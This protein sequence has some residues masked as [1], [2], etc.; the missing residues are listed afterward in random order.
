MAGE[1]LA[2]S[3]PGGEAAQVACAAET[4]WART[5][6]SG[7]ELTAEV[8]LG[9]APRLV[10]S[11]CLRQAERNL[12]EH[13]AGELA[14]E[15]VGEDGRTLSARWPVAGEE[16]WWRRELDLGELAGETV[17]LR[18][19]THLAGPRRLFLADAVVEHQ[20][21]PAPRRGTPAQV[22]LVSIDTLR[23][24][25]VAA[26]GGP[27]PTPALDRLV[28]EG[29]V[30]TRHYAG[31][32]WTKPSHANLLTGRGPE[33][34]RTTGYQ[35]VLHPAAE[36]LAERF[37][38]GGFR[39]AGLVHDCVWLNPEFGF[40]R[41]FDE[42]RAVKWGA[43]PAV[44]ET[45]GWMAEHRGEPFFYF[46]HL[47][48]VHSDFAVLPYEGPGVRQ[49]T[50]EERFGVEG[51]GC[52][53]GACASSMLI[54]INDG[55]EPIPEEGEILRFL[56]GRGVS[57]T[58]AALGAL[59]D[60]LRR[61]GMWDDLTVAVTAD[62]GEAFFEHGQVLHEGWWDEVTR[63]PLVIKWPRGA[64]AGT[65]RQGPS[66]SI[67]V[68][69]TLLTA[70]GLS[71]GDLPGADLR[72]RRADRPV[73]SGTAWRTVVAGPLKAVFPHRGPPQLYDLAGDPGEHRD[74]A[75]E[76]PQEVTRLRRLL[77][78]HHEREL[79][80]FERLARGVEAGER[81]LTDE[82][83]A[84]LRALGYLGD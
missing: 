33:V 67:D 53:W 5:V 28:T 78:A 84:R 79:A 45:S 1:R 37:R 61:L 21:P 41:G 54:R 58:D 13:G 9:A 19:T 16:G 81:A 25:G 32:N 26:L 42:Y 14:V 62:H 51:Y 70:A 83:R 47:F 52:R 82:E 44:R 4:H 17:R 48:D 7:E 43:E 3:L 29:E 71:P 77:D 40:G 27:W 68:A 23:A 6:R 63:V 64:G 80:D 11:A 73:F 50:V 76:R 15:A 20:L 56:Y 36:T 30:F 31:A 24:D 39:T 8:E 22:L 35:D 72:R 75:A 57:R 12:A 74:L 49:S 66:S 60:D 69:P 38:R 55:G 18:L 34:H 2:S 59:F 46:L 65:V 10:V